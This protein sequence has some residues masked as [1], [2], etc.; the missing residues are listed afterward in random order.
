M[1]YKV[2]YNVPITMD[3]LIS[4]QKS[5]SDFTCEKTKK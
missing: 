5:N 4:N 1:D 2:S 3:K